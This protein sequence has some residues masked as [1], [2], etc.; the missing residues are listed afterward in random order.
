MYGVVLHAHPVC[1]ESHNQRNTTGEVATQLLDLICRIKKSSS[2]KPVMQDA[3]CKRTPKCFDLSTIRAK[4]LKYREILCKIYEN[5]REIPEILGKLPENTDKNG[6]QLCLILKN[7]RPMWGE[8]H[9]DLF[10]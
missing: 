8:S 7:W 4:S 9:E 5:I 2:L 6:A 3:G 1:G 10:I